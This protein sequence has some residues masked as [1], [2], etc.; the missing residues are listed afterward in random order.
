[1]KFKDADLIGIPLRATIGGKDQGGHS[2]SSSGARKRTLQ[3]PARRGGG[4]HCGGR[5]GGGKPGMIVA[6]DKPQ[7]SPAPRSET[8][9]SGG[10]W[11]VVVLN[12]PVNLMS[13]VVMVFKKVFGFDEAR[14]RR[15][16]L[17]SRAGRSV[18]GADCARGGAMPSRCSNGTS[19][20]CWNPMKRVEVKLSLPV[21]EPLLGVIKAAGDSLDASWPRR[22][23][24]GP[25]GEFRDA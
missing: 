20:R 10:Q 8:N 7:L 16:M 9:S 3:G 24:D 6:Q 4:A 17:E 22:C 13:Y 15:H 2:S 23:D 21:V 18:S 14:A 25:R 1:V 19:P 12:D 11:R 5:D